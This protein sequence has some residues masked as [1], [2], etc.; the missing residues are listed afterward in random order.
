MNSVLLDRV[1]KA[2]CVVLFVLWLGCWAYTALKMF[3][4]ETNELRDKT[5]MFSILLLNLWAISFAVLM[6]GKGQPL[7][8]KGK[9]QEEKPPQLTNEIPLFFSLGAGA[10][11]VVSP[12]I[13]TSA[14]PSWPSPALP[15]IICIAPLVYVS[16]IAIWQNAKK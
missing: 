12:V 16:A 15:F 6:R 4:F 14:H 5:I 2:L 9:K 7:P 3:V 10:I 8:K 1:L 13:F 11:Y